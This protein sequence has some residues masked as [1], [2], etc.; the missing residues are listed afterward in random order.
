MWLES[1]VEH[2]ISELRVHEAARTGAQVLATACPHCMSN[3][4][5]AVKVAGY[6]DTMEV[7][8]IVELVAEA[9]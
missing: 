3:L 9:M 2:R 6:G 8:D 4:T 1:D 7:R 5:D